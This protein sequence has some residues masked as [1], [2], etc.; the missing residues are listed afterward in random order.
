MNLSNYMHSCRG[1]KS[2][3]LFGMRKLLPGNGPQL[4][5]V[6]LHGICCVVETARCIVVFSK[7]VNSSNSCYLSGSYLQGWC[8]CGFVASFNGIS[9]EM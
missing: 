3:A 7:L 6:R 1:C 9:V 4:Q 5:R 8:V 2:G